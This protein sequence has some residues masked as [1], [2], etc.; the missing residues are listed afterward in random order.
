M[1]AILPMDFLIPTLQVATNTEWTG[2][3]LSQRVNDLEQLYETQLMVVGHMY[4]QKRHQKQHHELVLKPKEL[5]KGD[6]FL[7][8]TLKPHIGK[9]KK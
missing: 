4:A 6:L 5:A 2:H 9:F 1:N 7:F 3:E 8:Y